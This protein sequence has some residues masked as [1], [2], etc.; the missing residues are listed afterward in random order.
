M[1]VEPLGLV[2]LILGLLGVLRGPCLTFSI[3]IP[4]TLLGSAAVITSDTLTV[5]PAH[6]MLGF[7]M[8]VVFS[9]RQH[10]I[11]S[12][13]GLS[14]PLP[15]FWLLC[16]MLYGVIGAFVFPR[17]LAGITYVNAIGRS[18]FGLSYYSIPLS[19]TSGNFTQSVYFIGDV[20][21]FLLCYSYASTP[22]GF[23]C[24]FNGLIYYSIGNIFFAV[25]DVATFWAGA[26]YLLD[27]IR[28]STY[29]L[30]SETVVLGLKR[31]I[32]SFTETSSFASATIGVLG[33]TGR[34]W[35]FNIAPSVTFPIALISLL[36][37]IFSTA[38]TAYAALPFVLFYLY[39][40][41][42]LRMMKGRAP[43]PVIAFV[44]VSPLLLGIIVIM[45]LLQPS[46]GSSINDLMDVLVFDKSSSQSG[47]ERG[48]MNEVAL[49]NFFETFGLGTGIGSVRASSFAIAILA[50]LGVFG[51]ATYCLFLY[52]L[53]AGSKSASD[54]MTTNI[55]AAARTACF[56]LLC[57]SII[58]G[59][60]IDLGLP[61]FIF[62]GL[63]CAV[64]LGARLDSRLKPAGAHVLKTSEV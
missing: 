14:F 58:S 10:L 27:F 19:P 47:I 30:H 33:F 18:D 28:N 16:T 36:L 59:T 37:L 51:S 15:G 48:M 5:Q 31:I 53:L 21:C 39:S 25:L 42:M 63:S 50:N 56:A 11:S 44:L 38:T 55:G 17:V 64:P 9:R 24:I 8:V 2:I 45:V 54:Q 3:F 12:F 4:C 26:P 6:L 41:S 7:V 43:L 13:E 61:F 60:L 62:A 49:G 1:S 29:V 20:I 35:L 46:V 40:G 34:L 52:K 57:A 32:G 22:A 23:R